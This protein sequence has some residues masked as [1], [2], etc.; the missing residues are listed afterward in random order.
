[1]GVD[2]VTLFWLS[3]SGIHETI[4]EAGADVEAGRTYDEAAV[5]AEFGVPTSRG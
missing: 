4:A 2:P 3:Q 1:V 5:K